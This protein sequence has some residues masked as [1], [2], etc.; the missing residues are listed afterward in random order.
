MLLVRGILKG[1][2]ADMLSVELGLHYTT[3]LELRRKLQKDARG[4]QPDTHQSL[5]NHE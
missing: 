4:W 5:S 3:V 2:P 1:E